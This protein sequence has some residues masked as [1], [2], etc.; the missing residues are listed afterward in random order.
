MSDAEQPPTSSDLPPRLDMLDNILKKVPGL[1]RFEFPP[2]ARNDP[3]VRDGFFYIIHP[4]LL[5]L[6]ST[7]VAVR[8]HLNQPL[9]PLEEKLSKLCSE[10]HP[11]VG[12]WREL[13]INFS[14]LDEDETELPGALPQET[15]SRL[16]NL[17]ATHHQITRAYI[18]WLLTNSMFIRELEEFF[19][20]CALQLRAHGF[21]QYVSSQ[22][23]YAF[24]DPGKKGRA[25]RHN[26]I[27]A[28]HGL[29]MRWVLEA[30][31]G[32]YLPVPLQSHMLLFP[33]ALSVNP[34]RQSTMG[35]SIPI[36]QPLAES[37]ELRRTL[38]EAPSRANPPEHLKGWIAIVRNSNRRK[39]HELQR[40]ERMFRFVHF[41]RIVHE[42]HPGLLKV[43]RA[44]RLALFSQFLGKSPSTL[45]DDFAFVRLA[46]GKA[47][48]HLPLSS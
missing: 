33:H 40:Y 25:D 38:E 29:L 5:Q 28:Y 3:F 39:A 19:S 13:P 12:F 47:D 26:L 10:H 42:R 15:T 36:T 35:V 30:L 17:L 48:W 1:R 31:A 21:P 46:L 23:Q 9:M 6:L 8:G 27:D 45:R 7:D 32:P 34:L 2:E 20:R 43:A 37:E 18:G 11:W 41:W 22:N 24:P 16:T 14:F 4:K 44:N